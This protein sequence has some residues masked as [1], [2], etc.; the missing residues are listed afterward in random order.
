MDKISDKNDNADCCLIKKDILKPNHLPNNN[1]INGKHCQDA[2][3]P[4]TINT[5]SYRRVSMSGSGTA[6]V[7]STTG[8]CLENGIKD[9][10]HNLSN[11][12]SPTDIHGQL[13]VSSD[14][15]QRL[16]L[17]SNAADD[18]CHQLLDSEIVKNS[19]EVLITSLK[20]EDDT[21]EDS[22]CSNPSTST[23]NLSFI[24]ESDLINDIVVI[25]NLISEDEVSINSNDCVYAYR[26]RD[27]D[28]MANE[29]QSRFDPEDETDFLEMDFDPDPA[30]EVEL[31]SDI[32]SNNGKKSI[33]NDGGHRKCH[34][35]NGHPNDDDDIKIPREIDKIAEVVELNNSR[36]R[37][38]QENIVMNE[39]NKAS[40]Q[41]FEF[42]NERD[43]D[44]VVP[45]VDICLKEKQP[46]KYTGTKPKIKSQRS[47]GPK[48][49]DGTSST[50]ISDGGNERSLNQLSST[51][52]DKNVAVEK[53]EF[54][55]D[56]FY[57]PP[58]TAAIK[59]PL[60]CNPCKKCKFNSGL[61]SCSHESIS[62]DVKPCCSYSMSR[63]GDG[64]GVLAAK[65][66]HVG[67]DAAKM[68]DKNTKL[69]PF[70]ETIFPEPKIVNIQ[71]VC[72]DQ[73]EL[74]EALVCLSKPFCYLFSFIVSFL[75]IH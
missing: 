30:S 56:K 68:N 34:G 28:P 21:D 24:S 29:M 54:F 3:I 71:S 6:I 43:T 15:H 35:I 53:S 2:E 67:L 47:K 66:Q 36:S 7:S 5:T 38:S 4:D 17:T 59:D 12:C 26:G 45:V 18:P 40:N 57:W 23:D 10:H 11:H 8:K 41:R 72:C 19:T 32:E 33:F 27:A 48:S 31:Y 16:P 13:H 73:K 64:I 50:T 63:S 58:S 65:T 70:T 61:N 39:A 55:G 74:I 60:Q 25:Q 14:V 51:I 52:F 75:G 42:L 49:I 1:N 37:D 20:F 62:L 22:N 46:E 44:W 69:V 9:L